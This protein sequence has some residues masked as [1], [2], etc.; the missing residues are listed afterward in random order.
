MAFWG[1][2]V[3]PGKPVTHT[4]DRA[5]GRLRI[6]QA[7]L[8]IGSAIQKSLVQCNVG[9]KSPVFLCAL[10]P[11]K[12]ESCHLDLEF[13]EA[14]QVI[15]SVIGPRSVYLTGYYLGGGRPSNLKDDSESYGEDIANTDT[16]G[17]THCAD[18]DEYE[19]SFIDDGN[20]EVFPPSPGSS[21]EVV[22]E[23]ML[24]N[25][26]AKKRKGSHKRLKKKYQS[27]ESDDDNNSQQIFFVNECKGVSELESEDDDNCPI[28]TLCKRVSTETS[29]TGN[30]KTEDDG[31]HAKTEGDGIHMINLNSQADAVDN[32]PERGPEQPNRSL[33]PSNKM[34]CEN[35]TKSKKK[36]KERTKEGKTLE[37]DG[38]NHNNAL[39]DH[40]S[41]QDKA[42][43]EKPATNKE[44]DWFLPTTE[45][46]TENA[47]KP[48]KR[49]K[50]TAAE[51]KSFEGIENYNNVLGEDQVKQNEVGSAK[52]GKD[53]SIRSE[54]DQKC[55]NMKGININSNQVADGDQPEDKNSKKKKK[56]SKIR[57]N[58]GNLGIDAPSLPLEENNRSNK[59][60]E[61]TNV[62]IKPSQG[63]TLSNGLIIEDIEMGKPDSKI[64]AP[65]KKIKV[66]YVGKLKENG[67]I[68]DSNIGKAPYKFRL[69]AEDVIDGWNLGLESMRVG[70]KRRLLI[71]PSMGYGSQGVG[72]NIPPNSWLVFEVE[73]VSV[74]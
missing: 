12:T 13:E 61:G 47:A 74:R 1:I 65:G 9:N 59:G 45:T 60:F 39:K 57:E 17:S 15:F 71:P 44:T 4:F 69:G 49:R 73:L 42:D 46:L 6:S 32:E 66:H 40:K 35:H 3:K 58:K 41:L 37:S 33:L 72:E 19:D 26:K 50:E 18:E 14:D 52:S 53:H 11:D 48:K 28:S 20:P 43:D 55:S 38:V 29:K 54:L 70:G 5:R 22:D 68:F 8:G 36:R 62:E 67:Q 16:D 31:S 21:D 63:R 25:K 2:E 30:T 23:E 7:T 56:K 34:G 24:E 27:I 51:G 10:L 64:A